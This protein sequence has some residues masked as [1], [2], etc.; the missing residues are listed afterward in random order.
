M[1][2]QMQPQMQWAIVPYDQ[3]QAMQQSWMVTALGEHG[4]VSAVLN[5]GGYDFALVDSG[6]GITACPKSYANDLPLLPPVQLPPLKSATGGGV[7]IIGRRAV[8]YELDNGEPITI[9]WNV[10]N[11]E[12]L[13]VSTC[14]SLA[15][16][17][18][19]VSI[20]HNSQGDHLITAHGDKVKLERHAGVPWLRLRRTR[21]NEQVPWQVA[22]ATRDAR[23]RHRPLGE[24]VRE[25]PVQTRSQIAVEEAMPVE[26]APQGQAASSSS[27][28]PVQQSTA[29]SSS[30]SGAQ[31]PGPD[32]PTEARRAKGVMIPV[33]PTAVERADHDLT[34]VWFRAW[35]SS[36][37][38]GRAPDDPHQRSAEPYDT[39]SR[40]RI[41]MDYTF[42]S[43]VFL[44]LARP[45]DLYTILNVLHI[46]MGIT[47]PISVR[48]KGPIEYAIKSIVDN[49]ADWGVKDV[50]LRTDGEPAITA[51]AVAVRHARQ[52]PTLL[53]QKPRY[54]PQSMGAI[55]NSNKEIK[56]LIRTMVIYL[57]EHA[58]VAVTTESTLLDWLVR[59]AGWLINHYA[60]RSD[61]K[62]AY[63]RLKGRPYG[64][65]I[66]M[67]G[68]CVWYRP[69]EQATANELTERWR[70]ALWLG[71]TNRSDEHLLYFKGEVKPARSIRRK[72]QAKRWSKKLLEE[73]TATPWMPK[74]KAGTAETANRPARYI[75]K[76][77][78]A[79]HGPTVGCAGC[80]GR[81]T[82][83]TPECR[84]RWKGIWQAEDKEAA[85]VGRRA[86]VE[87][88]P[89]AANAPEASAATDAAPG[90]PA[91]TAVPQTPL[92]PAQKR[93]GGEADTPQV[94][95]RL[96][97]DDSMAT[98][99]A[100]QEAQ[101]TMD[102]E[103]DAR[104]GH[105]RDDRETANVTSPMP[106][107][108]QRPRV[109]GIL[110]V[111]S[112]GPCGSVEPD[113]VRVNY[114]A[115]ADLDWKP[116]YDAYSGELLDPAM[117]RAGRD[118]ER[119]N[120]TEHG[121]YHRVRKADARGVK[122][123]CMWIDSVKHDSQG[124][125]FVRSRLVAMQ[126]NN[127]ER[128]DVFS[129]TPP[130]KFI[131][132]II[133]RAAARRRSLGFFD[134]EVAFWH[135]ALPEDEAIAVYPPRGEE[136]DDI[137]WQ[138]D[139]AMYGTRPASR[140]FG[141]L[142]VEVHGK[143]NYAV[144]KTSRQVSHSKD[145]DSLSALWGDD[146]ITEGDDAEHDL[147]ETH[148]RAQLKVKILERLGPNGGL[149]GRYLK[150]HLFYVPDDAFEWVEDPIHIER[151]VAR[152]GKQ[153]C[154][155]IGSPAS[156]DT[157][158]N[159]PKCLD[160]LDA[161]GAREYRQDT[162]TLLYVSSG[163]YDLQFACKRLGEQMATPKRMGDLRLAR[164]ARYLAGDEVRHLALVFKLGEPTPTRSRIPVDSDWA[165]HED[166][167]STHSG[168]ELIGTH[169]I[170]SWVAT[171]QV[172]ALSSAEA[173]LYGIVDGSARGLQTKHAMEECS[174]A[175]E[176]AV[177]SD[178]SAGI[179]LAT[180]SGVGKV[181]HI[182]T[183]WLWV[184]DAIRQ[185]KIGLSKC[186]GVDNVSDIG[187]K[188]LEP[189]RLTE[190]RVKLPLRPPRGAGW[191]GAV[192]A[193][194]QLAAAEATREMVRYIDDDYDTM[195]GIITWIIVILI[196]VGTVLWWRRPSTSTKAVRDQ[197]VQTDTVVQRSVQS[198]SQ[199]TYTAL[200]G[201][202]H[203]RFLPL[204]EASHG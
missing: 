169:M 48:E 31:L 99:V 8:C 197:A 21:G 91:A 120:A 34:H 103:D 60:V 5:M 184:Q 147:L 100:P 88:A 154:K 55:E 29:A 50:V 167:Y 119:R 38:K 52:F 124:K 73:V 136:H 37:V 163:R 105:K 42:F 66:A 23:E 152:R 185:K 98:D 36:C 44:G 176:V 77:L 17:G 35:C 89:A 67:F 182:E 160:E 180:R 132:L 148:L 175:W 13:I 39:Q 90:T 40:P 193:A 142:M 121:L 47:L 145:G 102:V 135:A 82:F 10:A 69:P 12:S 41:E 201:V 199:T 149:H 76:A 33:G 114:V 19:E 140:L 18:S 137:M 71:K 126:F 200:R 194:R 133:S 123:R 75:T 183:K 139:K 63:E 93:K 24:D 153:G 146:G 59:H 151:V 7:D 83:H 22:A 186:R 130:L 127:H 138:L 2:S 128:L 196:A 134:V 86:A 161:K 30:S 115:T 190:L 58:K 157:G 188:P 187:T 16:T 64:G 178:A 204:P 80:V 155:P 68:E 203:P 195:Y 112:L 74:P 95:K 141:D 72:E 70:T 104:Q 131:K 85:G 49:V 191:L 9:V 116:V 51:L 166:R 168:C 159:D 179:A 198:Q 6:S 122:V 97:V 106:P 53:E 56:G 26:P 109:A 162:G 118:R 144:L 189:K 81:A 20:V 54:S 101:N 4:T 156:K 62:T 57:L 150:R 28:G 171:D 14:N 46:G 32:P 11:V 202:G 92:Q 125:V 113:V 192:A 84:E 65:K 158:K 45:D 173:E 107:A 1:Q 181:R 15:A 3:A 129:G 172:R 43:S 111:C 174:T 117:V 78:I 25:D 170:D 61:G 177:E 108:S 87:A 165:G 94:Q 79:Q 110:P 143:A 27:S 164:V 96:D